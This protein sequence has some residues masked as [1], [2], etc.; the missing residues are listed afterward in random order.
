LQSLEGEYFD[1]IFADTWSGKYRFLDEALQLI[2]P[3]G[4]YIIDDM[5]PQPNWPDGHGAK[6]EALI[7]Y[8]ERD[9]RFFVTMMSWARGIILASKR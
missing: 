6:V 3:G 2:K 5:P 8:M 1:F 4:F 9:G 7:D